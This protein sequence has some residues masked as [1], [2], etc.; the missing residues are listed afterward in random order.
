MKGHSKSYSQEELAWIK[1]HKTQ[2]RRNAHARFCA[3]FDRKDISLTNYASLCKR[4]G[5]L[6]GRTGQ[7]APGQTPENK[8]KKMP[9]NANSAKTQFKKGRKPHNTNY[10][11]HERVSK[12]G[13]V[14]ISI[15]ETNPHTGYERRYVLKHR[16]IWEQAN[17]PLAKDMCLKCLSDDKTNT[18]L[19]NWEAIPRAMLPRL[20]GRFGRGYNQASPDIKPTIM[21]IAKLEHKARNARI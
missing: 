15:S 3:K 18:D 2:V 6:T 11:G 12:D 1:A 16:Y 9:Y 13:Y 4:M 14:E 20:N 21:T 5:W 17:G 7:Y 19:S 10:L 8:G